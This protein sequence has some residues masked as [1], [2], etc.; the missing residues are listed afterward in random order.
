MRLELTLNSAGNQTINL[1][2]HYQLSSA[3]YHIL[4]K[5]SEDYAKFLHDKGYDTTGKSFKLFN[6]ALKLGRIRIN[7]DHAV[8]LDHEIKLLISSPLKE[9]FI[10]NFILGLFRSESI[11]LT[12]Y[13]STVIFEITSARA[14]TMPELTD[15]ENF[16]LLSPLVL[17]YPRINDGKMIEQYV[18]PHETGEINRLLTLNLKNK[19]K[20]VYGEK[21][22]CN[23][24]KLIWDSEYH[25]K[26]KRVTKKITINPAG[27]N[28]TDVIG[29]QAPFNLSGDK[30]L[31]QL[32]LECGFGIK[33]SMGFGFA[34]IRK[35]V[36]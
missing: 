27:K 24:L 30:K 20:A 13:H 17:A 34:E 19:Y 11:V 29:I 6:F 16:S 5:G 32:G 26:K 23:E 4:N 21:Y 2:Y 1:N 31:I 18:R 12:G 28:P 9:E 36:K 3:I 14:L 25:E 15:S 7:L 10:Q 35:E 8:L 33:N 22:D